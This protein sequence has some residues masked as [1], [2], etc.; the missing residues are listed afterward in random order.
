MLQIFGAFIF[1]TYICHMGKLIRATVSEPKGRKYA[2]FKKCTVQ[3]IRIG[4][5]HDKKASTILQ[6]LFEDEYNGFSVP[7]VPCSKKNV[8]KYLSEHFNQ[9]NIIP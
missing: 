8:I 5:W 3:S 1:Y 6:F 7:D 2:E 4:G 9:V